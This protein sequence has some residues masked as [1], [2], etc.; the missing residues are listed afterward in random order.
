MAKLTFYYGVMNAGKSLTLLAFAAKLRNKNIPYW[1]IKPE[2]DTRDGAYISSRPLQE[3]L[4]CRLWKNNEFFEEEELQKIKYILVDE[5]QFLSTGQVDYLSF[6]VDTC[7]INVICYGLRTDFQAHLFEGSKRL[8][9]LADDLHEIE[10]IDAEGNKIIINARMKN[11]KIVIA[12]PQVEIG[13]EDK[14]QSMSRK[15]FNQ[16]VTALSRISEKENVCIECKEDLGFE[17]EDD[18]KHKYIIYGLAVPFG[19]VSTNNRFYLKESYIHNGKDMFEDFLK[20]IED[21]NVFGTLDQDCELDAKKFS[22]KIIDAEMKPD[23]I[24]I[25]A[26]VLDTPNG[27]ILQT[28][29]DCGLFPYFAQRAYGFVNEGLCNVT[30]LVGYDLVTCPSFKHRGEPVHLVEKQ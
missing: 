6:I 29:I 25:T 17:K 2:T 16:R 10:D 15:E 3:K 24:Y 11:G 21:G 1:V 4:P 19:E 22:H 20:R 14:Y 23:G 8:F 28:M 26:E 9:E 13:A 27:K 7:G 12:G 18:K 30:D 5:A